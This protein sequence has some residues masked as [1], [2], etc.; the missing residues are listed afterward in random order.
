MHG[1]RYWYQKI[2][3][4]TNATKYSN[5]KNSTIK[6]CNSFVNLRNLKSHVKMQTK[7]TASYQGTVQIPDQQVL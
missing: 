5:V 4:F 6:I 7:M 1:T 2:I 3:T